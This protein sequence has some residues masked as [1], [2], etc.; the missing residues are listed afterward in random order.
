M[1]RASTP[2]RFEPLLGRRLAVLGHEGCRP[3]VALEFSVNG[4]YAAH[5]GS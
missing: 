5:V 3:A 2:P 4:Q 1:V